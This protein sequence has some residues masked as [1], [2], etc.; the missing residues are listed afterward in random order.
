MF[1]YE[2]QLPGEVPMSFSVVADSYEEAI[3]KLDEMENE[4]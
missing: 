4:E 3:K 2:I 1:R